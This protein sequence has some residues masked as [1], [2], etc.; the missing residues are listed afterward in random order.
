MA[1]SGPMRYFSRTPRLAVWRSPASI[2]WCWPCVTG[3]AVSLVKLPSIGMGLIEAAKLI[4]LPLLY[5]VFGTYLADTTYL[6][7]SKGFLA[8][9]ALGSARWGSLWCWAPAWRSLSRR[10]WSRAT[11]FPI[12]ILTKSRGSI[13][14]FPLPSCWE[15]TSRW[16][17]LLCWATCSR[18]LGVGVCSGEESAS[19][20]S[21]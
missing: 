3:A 14:S 8:A 2:C 20:S 6:R 21:F 19:L 11:V 16:P 5:L 7:R 13:C 9:G 12:L 15:T 4:Y 1:S 18:T 17:C 10:R